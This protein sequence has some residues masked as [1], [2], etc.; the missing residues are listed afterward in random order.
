VFMIMMKEIELV[1]VP[2]A[3]TKPKVLSLAII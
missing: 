1:G 2:C 3:K